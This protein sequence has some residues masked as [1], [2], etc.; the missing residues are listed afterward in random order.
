[1]RDAE[2]GLRPQGGGGEDTGRDGPSVTEE[3]RPGVG[4]STGAF[5]LCDLGE[6]PC[7]SKPQFSSSVKW[8]C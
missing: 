5:Q 1:M 3:S 2:D 7:F 4:L 6:A 8:A